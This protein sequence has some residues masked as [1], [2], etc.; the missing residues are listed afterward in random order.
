MDGIYKLIGLWRR[1]IRFLIKELD[2]TINIFE[3]TS[4]VFC[5]KTDKVL[6]DLRSQRSVLDALYGDMG[7][8]I[9]KELVI[10]AKEL[11]DKGVSYKVSEFTRDITL[12]LH[13]KGITVWKIRLWIAIKIMKVATWVGGFGGL[14]V[15]EKSSYPE[16]P[17]VK[18]P[19]EDSFYKEVPGS[20]NAV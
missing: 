8:S 19:K 14:E 12:T 7:N 6:H 11:T 13:L 1:R 17:S 3:S 10:P 4:D 18:K 15:I 9:D 5:T 16:M 20:E 2:A